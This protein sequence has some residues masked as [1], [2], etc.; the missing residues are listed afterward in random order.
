M[1]KNIFSLL[2]LLLVATMSQAQR[3]EP[4]PYGDMEQWVVRIIKESGIIGGQTRELYC[5]GKSDTIRANKAYDYLR[6][7]SP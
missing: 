3:L 4:V 2:C 6:S 5:L 1:R 7:G